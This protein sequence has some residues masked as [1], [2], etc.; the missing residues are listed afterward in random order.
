MQVLRREQR[1][2]RVS[3]FGFVKQVGGEMSSYKS[4]SERMYKSHSNSKLIIQDEEGQNKGEQIGK[5][6][7]KWGYNDE[8]YRFGTGQ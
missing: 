4:E 2:T 8:Y 6:R 7:G 3:D 5:R 1:T